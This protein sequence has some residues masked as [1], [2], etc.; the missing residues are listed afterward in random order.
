MS[1]QEQ[2]ILRKKLEKGLEWSYEKML[3]EK[4]SRNENV[5]ISK[6]KRIEIISACE[7]M[8]KKN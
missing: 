1:E 8:N 3:K 7:I 2:L 5:V 6:N 4:A